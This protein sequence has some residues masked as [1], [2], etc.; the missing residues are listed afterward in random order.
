M[1]TQTGALADEGDVQQSKDST[2]PQLYPT[3]TFRSFVK[4]AQCRLTRYFSREENIEV[5][6]APE[7]GKTVVQHRE[8]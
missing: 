1:A 2:T 3:F 6:E 8:M 4:S 5:L 7:A